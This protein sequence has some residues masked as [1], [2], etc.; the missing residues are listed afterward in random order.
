MRYDKGQAGERKNLRM[1]DI[2]AVRQ[3][4]EFNLQSQ[5]EEEREED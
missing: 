5:A 3:L 2:K 4:W 1:K